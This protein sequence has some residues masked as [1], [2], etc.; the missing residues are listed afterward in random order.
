MEL[1]QQPLDALP[2]DARHARGRTTSKGRAGLS[3]VTSHGPAR[4][5]SAPSAS[6]SDSSFRRDSYAPSALA[7]VIDRSLHAATARL[8]AGRSPI[9]LADAYLDWASHLAFAPGKRWQLAEKAG[10][11]TVCFAT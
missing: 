5:R 7:D 4:Q 1:K 6:P 11:K 10:K 2:H 8:T 3:L 9:A